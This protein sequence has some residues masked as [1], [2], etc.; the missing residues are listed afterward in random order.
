MWLRRTSGVRPMAATTS[1]WTF[2]MGRILLR[3]GPQRGDLSPP[4]LEERERGVEDDGDDDPAH[5]R[6]REGLD[7]VRRDEQ[8]RDASEGQSQGRGGM[9]A[10]LAH[11]ARA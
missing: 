4:G 3:R 11:E 9:E 7:E 5:G 8:R 6:H 1:S 10:A 2:F